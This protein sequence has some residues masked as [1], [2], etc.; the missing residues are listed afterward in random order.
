MIALFEAFKEFVIN[1]NLY[2]NPFVLRFED[3][4]FHFRCL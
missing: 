1:N 4:S 2:E 3:V